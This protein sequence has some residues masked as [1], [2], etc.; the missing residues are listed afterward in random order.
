MKPGKCTSVTR[1][2]SKSLTKQL[3][4]VRVPLLNFS[5][6][7]GKAYIFYGR[8]NITVKG[9]GKRYTYFVEPADGRKLSSAERLSSG[10]IAEKLSIAS[11][12]P[13]ADSVSFVDFNQC[14][15]IKVPPLTRQQHSSPF[16]EQQEDERDS[17]LVVPEMPPMTKPRPSEERWTKSSSNTST[18]NLWPQPQVQRPGSPFEKKVAPIITIESDSRNSN[19]DGPKRNSA[20]FIA[21]Q[22]EREQD[23]DSTPQ[24]VDHRTKKNCVIF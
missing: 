16:I 9:L 21:T 20:L 13:N 12:D 8:G 23:V 5:E 17:G 7:R 15:L 22:S 10:P 4:A 2:T 24:R 3:P 1:H 19:E 18:Q 6:L 14:N 11:T